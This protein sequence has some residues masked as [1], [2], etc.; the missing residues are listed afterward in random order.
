MDTGR[1]HDGNFLVL[2]AHIMA[3]ERR[4]K[5]LCA[6]PRP[7]EVDSSILEF[8]YIWSPGGFDL[9]TS[10]GHVKSS[11]VPQ[12]LPPPWPPQLQQPPLSE[13]NVAVTYPRTLSGERKI[14]WLNINRYPTR[15]QNHSSETWM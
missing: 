7:D 2:S 13:A 15:Y 1:E 11:V 6:E 8:S 10:Q 9:G 12:T 14:S 3:S 5:I 4:H